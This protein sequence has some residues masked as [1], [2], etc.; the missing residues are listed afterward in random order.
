MA[1]PK[2]CS[3]RSTHWF[4]VRPVRLAC[5]IR[6]SKLCWY[7]NFVNFLAAGVLPPDLNYQQKK[8]FFNDL[9]HYY[10][11]KPYFFKRGLD[12]IFRRCIPENEVSN[13]LNHC[14]S[15]SCGGHA[16]TQKTSFKILQSGFWWPSLFKDVHLFVFKCDQCQRTCNITKRNEM[17]L[18]NILEVE[19]F[20][21]WSIDFMGPF[22]SFFW[23]S[24]H[25]GGG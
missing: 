24:L 12:G 23:K 9:K 10:L 6:V 20:D 11:D 4:P 5:S 3:N 25:I 7:A 22:P 18:N 8:K 21:V 1:D 13:I 2:V 14:H 19:I 17:P 15:S 16:G